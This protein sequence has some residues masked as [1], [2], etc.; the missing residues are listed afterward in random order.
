MDARTT[1][2]VAALVVTAM[3]AAMGM[4]AAAGAQTARRR[5]AATGRG[6]VGPTDAPRGEKRAGR[7]GAAREAAASVRPGLRVQ[8]ASAPAD[9]YEN[10]DTTA[11]AGL[12]PD[13]YFFFADD[14]YTEDHTLDATSGATATALRDED[15]Y[16]LEVTADEIR[17][18]GYAV[19]VEAWTDDPAVDTVIEVYRDGV[20]PADPRTLPDAD[21]DG[22]TDTDTN[23]LFASDEDFWF[24]NHGSS[25]TIIFDPSEHATYAG[26][27]H[28]RVRPY[29]QGDFPNRPAWQPI[30]FN[31]AAGP[32][33]LRYKLGQAE[34]LYSGTRFQTAVRISQERYPDGYCDGYF[35]TVASGRGF[36]D[37]LAGSTLAGA[38]GGPLLLTEPT[39]LPTDVRNEI[40]RLAADDPVLGDQGTTTVFVLGGAAA[41]GD[42]VLAAIDAIPDVDVE[43]ITDPT[44]T[45]RYGTAAEIARTADA[46][47]RSVVPTWG[48]PPVAFIASGRSFPDALAAS[49]MATWNWAPILLTDRTSLPPATVDAIADLGITDVV[50]VGGTAA[51]SAN[52]E[53]QLNGLLGSTHVDRIWG[54]T[55]YQTARKFAEWASDTN[56]T[57]LVGT[58]ADPSLL[59]VLY[60]EM[61][62]L[63]NGRNFPDALAGGVLCGHAGYPLLLN[64]LMYDPTDS[65]QPEVYTYLD[66]PDNCP[67]WIFYKP[68]AFGGTGA[69]SAMDFLFFDWITIPWWTDN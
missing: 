55:R 59:W 24:A 18:D 20:A 36:A 58:E 65:W 1:K 60:P 38:A 4:P 64:D 43:R 49:P 47:I 56:P 8:A 63:A 25:V 66:N 44:Y 9:S 51:V 69:I 16:E 37:A 41:V 27:Y 10:D 32:Y 17:Y 61:V 54:T 35:V 5:P 67:D 21:D 28:I 23:A 12:L 31:D 22:Y 7:E 26:T 50:I 39:S 11:T 46:V 45:T 6:E 42:S 29:Y 57:A 14:P 30:G 2:V 19:L 34:R 53:T 48:V 52:V 33:V 3:I 68:Y 40:T 15:W 13:A 62:G